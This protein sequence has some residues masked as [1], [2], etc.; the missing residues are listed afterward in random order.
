MGLM[1]GVFFVETNAWNCPGSECIICE[2]GIFDTAPTQ[3]FCRGKL[4]I[5]P[6]LPRRFT[7]CER[8][9]VSCKIVKNARRNR[10]ITNN[11][12]VYG[13]CC[14]KATSTSGEEEIFLRGENKKPRI[15]YFEKVE[16]IPCP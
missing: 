6:A 13:T 11:V 7:K 5:E 8:E 4:I 12:I 10:H 3:W 2:I 16:S 15:A 9:E 14:W 1:A